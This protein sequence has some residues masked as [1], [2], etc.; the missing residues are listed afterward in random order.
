M[1]DMLHFSPRRALDAKANLIQFVHSC[2]QQSAVFGLDLDFDA[3][4]WDISKHLGHK[5]TRGATRLRFS[6]WRKPGASASTFMEEPFK[7]FVKAYM[8]YQQGLRPSK[9]LEGRLIALRA[10]YEVLGEGGADR[11]PTGLLPLHF[12]RSAQLISKR[13]KAT[14]AY[15]YGVQLELIYETM[16]VCGL[17]SH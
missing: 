14:S 9:S 15:Q 7:S 5:G 2:R 1:A 17:L 8:R 6:P 10:L 16:V 13:V 3:D 11:D 12:D 4:V